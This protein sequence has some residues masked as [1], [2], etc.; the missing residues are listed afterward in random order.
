VSRSWGGLQAQ[1]PQMLHMGLC[2]L[3]FIHSDAGGFAQGTKDEELY[4]RWLQL[5][6]FSPILRPH[7]SG[8]PSEPVYFNDTTQQIVR[9]F[10]KLRYQLLPYIY[11]LAFQAN[12]EGVPIVRPLFYEFPEDQE[13]Y[14]IVNQYMFGEN[15]LVA[16]VIKRGQKTMQVY[17]P[18]GISWYNFWD[19]TKYEGGQWIDIET[20]L[21]TMPIFVKAGSFIPM[22][23][24][25]NSTDDY[26]SEKMTMRYYVDEAEIENK[27]I[28]Y[29][30]DGNTFRS[31]IKDTGYEMISFSAERMKETDTF[32]F[33][34]TDYNVSLPYSERMMLFEMIGCS[35]GKIG[36]VYLIDETRAMSEIVQ[37]G[38]L[39][40][41]N[42]Y[43]VNEQ[44]GV[45]NVRFD[46]KI[47]TKVSISIHK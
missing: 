46:W 38:P 7:G 35:K 4:T 44:S 47:N 19:N 23:A 34:S 32:T 16:P 21:E 18:A 40:E 26:S 6:C 43:L 27:G 45:L 29:E 14:D 11:T 31:P 30:D 17:L 10:M 8:I 42:W 15:M 39:N 1:L 9:S 37:K 25:V 5:S 24:A 28:I 20:P 13:T 36:K 22:V 33:K 2:G 41:T 12:T 3:P